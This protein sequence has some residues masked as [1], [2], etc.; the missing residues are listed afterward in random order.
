MGLASTASAV[1]DDEGRE[2][3]DSVSGGVDGPGRRTVGTGRG[4]KC[5]SDRSS[6]VGVWLGVI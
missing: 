5:V 6:G 1:T 4:L 3:E 2:T